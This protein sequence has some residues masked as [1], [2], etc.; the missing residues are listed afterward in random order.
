MLTIRALRIH[1]RIMGV[2]GECDVVEFHASPDGVPL[3]G[4]EGLWQPF[5]VEYKR[6]TK[7]PD[8]Y[9]E[10]QLCAQAIC[11][12]EMLNCTIPQGALY[13]GQDRHRQ[14]VDFTTELRERVQKAFSEMH[15]YMSRGTT[16]KSK[17]T[18]ACNAC[19]MKEICLP[20]L[21]KTVSVKKYLKQA[22]ES[23]NI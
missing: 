21:E 17:R 11:L 18:K 22:L 2:S 23:D 14:L 13:Y 15:H 16:P 7:K 9:D 5:P 8:I 20:Q 10:A 6:G 12:E 3:S 19:S 1:S 4:E